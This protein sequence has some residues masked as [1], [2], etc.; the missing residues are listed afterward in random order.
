MKTSHKTD[1]L[2]GIDQ[3]VEI[4][5]D[6]YSVYGNTNF[7][8]SLVDHA[9][10]A[11]ESFRGDDLESTREHVQA[12]V[13]VVQDSQDERSLNDEYEVMYSSL[14]DS[15]ANTL[16]L[17][18]QLQNNP[19]EVIDLIE[20]VKAAYRSENYKL[21]KK[22]VSRLSST[23]READLRKNNPFTKADVEKHH[24]GLSDTD[25][26]KWVSI[27]NSVYESCV[28]DGV[29]KDACEVRAIKIANSKVE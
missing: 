2:G 8:R 26:D 17:L 22:I 3:I 16:R 9:N 25:K 21:A 15:A 14:V 1:I 13:D 24:K 19:D 6:F 12:V 4:A 5:N 23:L 18:S 11:Q 10:S 28:Q 20:S 27:A 7:S 29:A